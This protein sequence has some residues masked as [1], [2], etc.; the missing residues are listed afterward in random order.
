ML[1]TTEITP[2]APM[3]IIGKVSESSPERRTKS[4]FASR[5]IWLAWSSEPLASLMPTMVGIRP[6]HDRFRE[7][8]DP[9]AAGHVVEHER[10]VDRLR[11]R[12]EVPVQSVWC[13]AVVVRRDHERPVGTQ[14]ARSRVRSMTVAVLLEPVPART[15]TRPPAVSTTTET[16]RSHSG[17]ARAP[18]LHRSCHARDKT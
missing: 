10:Q 2:P 17:H 9:G 15:G 16:T 12:R 14:R 5:V 18:A 13:R 1:E 7:Q 4:L 8:I 11:N 3:P 6:T